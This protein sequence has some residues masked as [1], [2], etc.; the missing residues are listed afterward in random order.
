MAAVHLGKLVLRWC[1]ACNVP[2]IVSDACGT[3]GGPAHDV[4]VTPPG[5]VRPAFDFDL[6]LIRGVIDSQFGSGCGDALLPKGKIV[7]LNRAPDLDKMDEV[8]LDGAVAGT[9]RYDLINGYS[10]LPRVSA[11]KVMSGAIS[12]NYVIIDDGAIPSMSKGASAL[13]PGVVKADPGIKRGDEVVAL[14]KN[15]CVIAVG[16]ARMAGAAMNRQEHGQAVKSRWYE[17]VVCEGVC[18]KP[19]E[20]QAVNQESGVGLHNKRPHKQKEIVPKTW[21]DVIAANTERLKRNEESAKTFILNT[22]EREKK[23]VAV[24]F[25]GGKDSLATLLLVLDAGVKPSVMFVD[26]GIEFEET[27]E[28]VKRMMGKLGVDVITDS[29]GDVFFRAVE[30]F[31]P[32]GR[33]FRWCCKTCKLAPVGRMV[34]KH[35]PGGVLSFIG[36]RAYESEQRA[37]KSQRWVNEWVPGQIGA[38]PIQKWTALEV[39]LYIFGKKTEFNVWYEKGLER[40]GCWTC[41]ASSMGD[42]ILMEKEY[43]N[44]KKW[45][46]FL[47]KYAKEQGY[48]ESWLRY[49][50][51]RWRNPPRPVIDMCGAADAQLSACAASQ[52]GRRRKGG[53]YTYSSSVEER[54]GGTVLEGRFEYPIDIDYLASTFLILGKTEMKDGALHIGPDIILRSDGSFRI[55]SKNQDAAVAK[56]KKAEGIIERSVNCLACGMCVNQ[57]RQDAITIDMNSAAKAKN[58]CGRFKIDA[59]RCIHCGG[60]LDNCP[61]TSFGTVRIFSGE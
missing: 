34:K 23:P 30:Y 49:G 40:I 20:I 43:P 1:D 14:T 58:K 47:R 57:C 61:I 60:C 18:E 56:L 29:A 42:I 44:Y 54:S 4:R 17:N 31:G 10:F 13:G 24:S 33:D 21:G 15:R 28:Y 45:N 16:S 48:S 27:I 41:P 8:I 2:I 11:A 53:K 35:F 59:S 9:L 6:K 7:I 38:S 25:S 19:Q 46:D 52:S 51:W 22:I 12:K 3:C 50:L 26:T 39:W 32:P 5:D 37:Q 36:Q 55:W